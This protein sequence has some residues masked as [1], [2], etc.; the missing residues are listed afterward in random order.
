M[1]EPVNTV[2]YWVIGILV[3]VFILGFFGWL[4]FRRD[5]KIVTDF[6][7]KSGINTDGFS[8]THSISSAT[9]MSRERIIKICKAS[10]K[11]RRS[12]NDRDSWKLH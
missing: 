1:G 3:C 9:N 8:T 11:I 6:L 7:E 4:K 2:F 10:S 12:R 5:E